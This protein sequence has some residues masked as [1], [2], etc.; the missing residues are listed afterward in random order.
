MQILRGL[1]ALRSAALK[2]PVATLGTFDGVHLGHQ[3]VLRETV[4]WAR[5]TGRIPAVVTFDTHP[6]N[7]LS[8]SPPRL[9][10]PLEER[11]ALLGLA[12]IEATLLL[13]FTLELAATPPEDFTR[14]ILARRVGVRGLVLGHDAAFGRNREGN[15]TFL[16]RIGPF[17]GMEVREV[18]PV[19]LGGDP[20]SS[21][22]IR[23]LVEKGD[24]AEAARMLGRSVGLVG[25]VVRGLGRGKSL[26]FPTANLALLHGVRPPEGVWAGRTSIDGRSRLAVISIGSSP[27][28]GQTLPVAVEVH[29]LD[30]EG[31]L[32]GRRLQVEVLRRIRDQKRFPSPAELVKAISED[33][34]SARRPS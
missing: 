16:R 4:R 17:L 32:V 28:F 34:Q 25:Q 22:R 24:V 26:G 3:A 6:R 23:T 18:P 8:G 11:L 19:A 7:V 14:D 2:N 5:D 30:F 9:L 33:V 13:P 27:T 10:M 20:V 1:D 31:D 29:V 21:S 15:A 12:G